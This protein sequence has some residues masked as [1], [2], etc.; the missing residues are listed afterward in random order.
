MV[1]GHQ[2]HLGVL[3][4]QWGAGCPPV[5][6][7]ARQCTPTMYATVQ[8]HEVIA[9][10]KEELAAARIQKR[11]N[12]EY[13]VGAPRTLHSGLTCLMRSER[14]K[15]LRRNALPCISISPPQP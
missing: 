10:R 11:H 9:R 5:I 6:E 15:S 1:L 13:E 4:A 8:A 14:S 3:G 12:E 7:H 2:G